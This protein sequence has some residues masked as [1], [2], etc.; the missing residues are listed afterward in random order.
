[1][2][3][4]GK[5]KLDEETVAVLALRAGVM[6]RALEKDRGRFSLEPIDQCVQFAISEKGIKPDAKSMQLLKYCALALAADT[7]GFT[8]D[9]FQRSIKPGGDKMLTEKDVERIYQITSAAMKE[10]KK[11]NGVA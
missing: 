6:C 7:T 9:F 11:M 1:M 10:V 3:G 2:F 5:H 4:F 8:E